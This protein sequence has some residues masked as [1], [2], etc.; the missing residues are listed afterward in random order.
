MFTTRMTAFI[1]LSLILEVISCNL[2]FCQ[3]PGNG[4]L[5]LS[6][7]TVECSHAWIIY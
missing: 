3:L 2:C 1:G 6:V 7:D 4:D 5:G